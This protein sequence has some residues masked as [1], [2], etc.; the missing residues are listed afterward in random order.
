MIQSRNGNAKMQLPN[1]KAIA[2]KRKR[3]FSATE[4]S[5]YH[6]LWIIKDT[7][8]V[9]MQFHVF[10][11]FSNVLGMEVV[12]I[13]TMVFHCLALFRDVISLHNNYLASNTHLLSYLQSL[14]KN[15]VTGWYQY[16]MP[17]WIFL[18]NFTLK[19]L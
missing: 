3:Q 5:G 13:N 1:W 7:W 9:G 15:A 2:R 19:K 16:E 6:S 8:L 14:K 4:G 10:S 18:E 11:L 12:C 17:F